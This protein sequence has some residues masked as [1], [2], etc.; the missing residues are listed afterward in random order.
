MKILI[1][2]ADISI[3]KTYELA[4]RT[5]RHHE[6]TVCRTKAEAL[7]SFRLQSHEAAIVHGDFPDSR[8]VELVASLRHRAPVDFTVIGLPATAAEK[9]R[10]EWRQ[11]GATAVLGPELDLLDLLKALAVVEQPSE[12]KPSPFRQ[13]GTC[14]NR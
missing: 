11:A 8:G 12:S 9:L 1:A 10:G 13:E 2:V 6:L 4:L 7:E 14:T 3:A 5:A